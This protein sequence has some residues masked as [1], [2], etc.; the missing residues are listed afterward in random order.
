M[1]SDPITRRQELGE[2]LKVLRERRA[3]EAFGFPPGR[4]RR[5]PGL[6]REEV[7]QLA[8][9]SPTWYTWIEQGRDVNV[10]AEV[11]ARLASTLQLTRSERA[12]LFEMAG[13]RDEDEVEPN[14][15]Q[16]PDI[17]ISLL[18]DIAPPVYL[19]GRYWDLLGWNANAAALFTGWLDM[20]QTRTPNLLR[21]VFL[22]TLA[23]TLLVDW[24]VRA[25][26]I[27]AEFRADCR[28]RLE[29][30]ALQ[31]LVGELTEESPDFARYWKQHDVV[32]RQGGRRD[33]QHATYGI[34]SYQQLT[35]HPVDQEALKLVI[36]EPLPLAKSK[37]SPRN[38]PTRA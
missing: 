17:L 7:A 8:G 29:E 16:V 38:Q 26:R 31:R 22:D 12:Y 15:D 25:R 3:P 18:D 21:F 33:F 37:A 5:A 19:M 1:K 35:M 2:F 4:R 34:V 9:I 13:R 10:S 32:D 30:P 6:R 36:L 14:E 11:L 23:R 20:P 24:E 27:V 28:T